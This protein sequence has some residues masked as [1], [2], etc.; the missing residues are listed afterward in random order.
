MLNIKYTNSAEIDL[1]E[2]IEYINQTSQTNAK[3]YLIKYENKIELLRLNPY[4]GTHCKNKLI[5]KDCRVLI[6]ESHIIIYRVNE[7]KNEILIVRIFHATENYQ[8]K[9]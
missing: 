6:F 2:A 9:V 7:E 5:K 4:M 8:D 3:N 1:F